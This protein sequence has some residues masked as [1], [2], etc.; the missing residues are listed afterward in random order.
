MDGPP[1]CSA[2]LHVY[3]G[4]RLDECE[5]FVC[6]SIFIAI[7]FNCYYI[8]FPM[9]WFSKHIKLFRVYHIITVTLTLTLEKIYDAILPCMD[10]NIFTKITVIMDSAKY[11][12]Y[13]TCSPGPFVVTLGQAIPG[14]F[15]SGHLRLILWRFLHLVS[16]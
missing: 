7:I 15:A 13:D 14:L 5:S 16:A 1:Y 3:F 10:N 12:S 8:D 2:R 4:F 9:G 6:F 11:D